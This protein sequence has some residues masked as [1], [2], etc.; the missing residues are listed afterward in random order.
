M[1]I[2]IYGAGATGCTI[3]AELSGNADI[4]LS[5]IGRGKNLEALQQNGLK[6]ITQDGEQNIKLNCFDEPAK[7]G[8]VDYVII[9]TKSFHLPEIA[10]KL[11]VLLDKNT[12]VIP[13][14][15]GIPW[16]FFFNHEGKLKDYR[17]VCLDPRG[18]IKKN[19]DFSQVIGGVFYMGATVEAPGVV[20]N[21][22]GPRFLVGE[23]SGNKTDRLIKLV[24]ILEKSGFKRPL[25]ENIRTEIWRKLCWNTPFNPLAVITGKNSEEMGNNEE[26]TEIARKVM[27]EMAKL[28]EAIGLPLNLDIE[29]HIDIA[30]TAGSHKPSMLQDYE[31]GKRIEI[32]AIIGSVC[33]IGQTLGV[34]MPFTESIHEIL[35][36]KISIRD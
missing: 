4:D 13:A 8:K 5:I 27:K 26:I 23:P 32:E 17:I 12:V 15:N 16:W 7:V 30:K 9:A 34:D 36:R 22:A 11:S 20:S 31:Q 21:Y 28:A 33:E 25:A 6:F 18:I 3:A 14:C 24:G 29:K 10:P 19:I 1:K 35:R 2:C